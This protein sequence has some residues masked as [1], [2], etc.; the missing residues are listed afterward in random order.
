MYTKMEEPLSR[1]DETLRLFGEVAAA[2]AD[3]DEKH[4]V[5]Y[6]SRSEI[7]ANGLDDPSSSTGIPIDVGNEISDSNQD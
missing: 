4:H 5:S 1:I 2:I 3:C 6:N 7:P